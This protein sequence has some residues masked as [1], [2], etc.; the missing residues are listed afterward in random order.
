MSHEKVQEL[1]NAIAAVTTMQQQIAQVIAE[2][3][4]FV[5]EHKGASSD[6]F[7]ITP[8]PEKLPKHMRPPFGEGGYKSVLYGGREYIKREA[9]EPDESSKT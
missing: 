7:W 6:G 3:E 1:V 5:A 2:F 8:D 9:E 4:A